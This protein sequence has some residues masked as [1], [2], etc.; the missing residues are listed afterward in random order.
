M[1]K[2]MLDTIKESPLQF[3]FEPKIENENEL[4]RKKTVIVGGMGGSNLATGFLWVYN[5]KLH[6]ITHRSYGLPDA[7]DEI[8]ND[9]M[10]IASSYSGNTEET[11]DFF[12][13]S[14]ERGLPL[15][16]ITAGGRLLE[17]AKERGVPF[18]QIP[19]TGIEPRAAMAFSFMA[20]LKAIGDGGALVEMAKLADSLNPADYENLG[21]SIADAIKGHVPVIYSSTINGPLAR[22]WKINLNESGKTPSFY[23]VFPELNHNEMTSFS[24]GGGSA[25]G[26]DVHSEASTLSEKFHFIFLSDDTDN[27]R[28]QKRM[29]ITNK[30]FEDKGMPVEI[31]KLE[32]GR[33][34]FYKIFSSVVLA[35]WTAHFVA[36]NYGLNDSEVPMVE[37]FKKLME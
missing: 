5:P 22:N 31:V 13:K 37:E 2:S 35:Q 23:N 15:I 4:V 27:S 32:S 6:I 28:I 1:P 8:L 17:L 26:G 36:E 10:A 11:I 12:N 20:L 33:G 34:V 3:K 29:E 24:A 7:D 19:D 18:I 25:F 16:A 21:K 30:M 9:S 14:K